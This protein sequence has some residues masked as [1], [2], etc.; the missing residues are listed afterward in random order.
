MRRLQPPLD[1]TIIVFA[2]I[3]LWRVWETPEVKSVA[4]AM[5]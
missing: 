2:L 1:R 4:F 3:D 5:T